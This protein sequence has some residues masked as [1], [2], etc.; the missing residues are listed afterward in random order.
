MPPLGDT[1]TLPRGVGKGIELL[2]L[3]GQGYIGQKS[4]TDCQ[5][6]PG[7]RRW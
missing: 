6:R 1:D 5:W 7:D 4:A 2:S 3:R